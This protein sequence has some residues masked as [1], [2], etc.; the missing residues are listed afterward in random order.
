MK[1]L[2]KYRAAKNPRIFEE[3]IEGSRGAAECNIYLRH[4]Q[5]RLEGC[6]AN[7]MLKIESI[8]EVK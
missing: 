8:S 7:V 1:W 3:T 2:I 4:C 6:P 5:N